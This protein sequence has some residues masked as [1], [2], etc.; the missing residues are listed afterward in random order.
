MLTA[1]EPDVGK[2]LFD[3]MPKSSYTLTASLLLAMTLPAIS[4]TT[5][6]APTSIAYTT[7]PNQEAT[8]LF[9]DNETNII[10]GSGLSGSPTLA[11]Y[12]TIQHAG[13]TLSTPGN[14]W[15]TND[16]GPGGGD[17]FADGG[18]APVFL[19]ALDQT[20][21]LDGIVFWGYHFGGNNG[22][23]PKTVRLELS[24]TGGASYAAP[25]DLTISFP[26]TFN[27]A[28]TTN[29][30]AADANFLRMTVIDNHFGSGAPG[31]DRVGI[32]ELRLL[33]TPVPEPSSVLL[34]ALA[35]LG[36]MARR[37]S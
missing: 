9:L 18:I 2:P 34:G 17:F 3:P 4:A 6:I 32:A 8:G 23:A 35:V 19:M 36:L 26:G 27:L 22:N 1:V 16:T 33:A 14:A 37:R 12:A 31:G 5:L 30:A 21:T 11:N 24:T 20:Y 10:N 29:F 13:V 28:S 7:T 15:A 25:L